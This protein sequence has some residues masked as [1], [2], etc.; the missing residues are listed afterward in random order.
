[1]SDGRVLANISN[2]LVDKKWSTN[3][4]LRFASDGKINVFFGYKNDAYYDS[5]VGG[6]IP[7][8]FA[9]GLSD[10]SIYKK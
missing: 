8:S 7:I 9:G 1:M 6:V 3:G 10:Y 5:G 2:I 4:K